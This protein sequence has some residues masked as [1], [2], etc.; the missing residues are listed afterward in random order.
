MH[1]FFILFSRF[2]NLI[3]VSFNLLRYAYT[4]W[5]WSASMFQRSAILITL[6]SFWMLLRS[7]MSQLYHGMSKALYRYPRVIYEKLIIV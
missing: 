4:A 7:R 3:K 6:N 1:F 5:S 2:K